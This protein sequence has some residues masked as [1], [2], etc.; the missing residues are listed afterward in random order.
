MAEYPNYATLKTEKDQVYQLFKKVLHG[1]VLDNTESE[2][3]AAILEVIYASV[4]DG[5]NRQLTKELWI[6][7]ENPGG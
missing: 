2:V 3:L 7:K 4:D 6:T 1:D 5:K